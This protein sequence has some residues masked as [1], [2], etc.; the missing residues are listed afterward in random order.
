MNMESNIIALEVEYLRIWEL[1]TM[2][3]VIPK[4]DVV[5]P[6]N[7]LKYNSGAVQIA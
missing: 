2:L 3:M 1:M 6:I 4:K 5:I 7:S